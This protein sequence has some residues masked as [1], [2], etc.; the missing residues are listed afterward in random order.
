MITLQY[1]IVFYSKVVLLCG[2]AFPFVIW[3]L[4]WRKLETLEAISHHDVIVRFWCY[5]KFRFSMKSFQVHN[6]WLPE[7]IKY[8]SKDAWKSPLSSRWC[9]E[10]FWHPHFFLCMRASLALPRRSSSAGSIRATCVNLITNCWGKAGVR[11]IWIITWPR[12]KRAYP[13]NQRVWL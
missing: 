9:S 10:G 7:A 4:S 8:I 12:E 2:I 11:F 3:W 5:K 1:S 6:S 13:Y